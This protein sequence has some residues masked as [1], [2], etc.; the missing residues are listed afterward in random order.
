[1]TPARLTFAFTALACLGFHLWLGG[2]GEPLT[3]EEADGYLE[4]I[5]A[6]AVAQGGLSTRS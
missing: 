2:A 1:M 5:R 4:R 3:I 6:A